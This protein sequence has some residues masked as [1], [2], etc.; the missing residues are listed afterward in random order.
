MFTDKISAVELDGVIDRLAEA[1]DAP[2]D[3]ALSLKLGLS[4]SGIAMARRKNSLP[5]SAI[6]NSC[7]KYGLSTDEIFGIK[8]AK[9]KPSPIQPQ[10]K[11]P[12]KRVPNVDDLIAADALVEKVLDDVLFHKNLPADRE[13]IVRKKLRPK[14]IQTAFK[15]DL[16]E[17]FVRTTAEGA[18]HMA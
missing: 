6:V 11:E 1:F 9:S 14:L 13:L 12:E 5:Y 10:Q 18:L 16:N 3:R 8:V 7:A 15:Y 4:H 2:S 17:L